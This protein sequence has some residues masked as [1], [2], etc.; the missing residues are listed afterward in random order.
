MSIRDFQMKKF[1]G[2]GVSIAVQCAR[3]APLHCLA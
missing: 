3:I 1:L 2:K